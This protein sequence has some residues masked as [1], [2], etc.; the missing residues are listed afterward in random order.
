MSEPFGT[1][2]ESGQEV[3]PQ[4][5][6][7]DARTGSLDDEERAELE[8]FRRDRAEREKVPEPGEEPPNTHWLLL[9]N[10]ETVE[11][12]GVSTHYKDIPVIAAHPIVEKAE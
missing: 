9:A 12:A 8:R 1:E 7:G 4:P 10:G 11:S 5:Q 6:P 2:E 3:K